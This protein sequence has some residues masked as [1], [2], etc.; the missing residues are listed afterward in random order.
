MTKFFLFRCTLVLD[1]V[2][3]ERRIAALTF[4]TRLLL[5]VLLLLI[6]DCV[7]VLFVPL[8]TELEN[9]ML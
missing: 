5:F 6:L 8:P 9:S 4:L 1:T 7:S 2:V 3:V